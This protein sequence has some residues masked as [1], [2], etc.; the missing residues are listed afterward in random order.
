MRRAQVRAAGRRAAFNRRA[1]L[2]A[3]LAEIEPLLRLPLMAAQV[4]RAN[5][6]IVAMARNAPDGR[7]ANLAMR[8]MSTLHET[9]DDHTAASDSRV[10]VLLARLRAMLEDEKASR[11]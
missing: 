1:E 8:L 9:R 5:R 4:E 10:A 3:T 11:D 6:L 2:R 7:I